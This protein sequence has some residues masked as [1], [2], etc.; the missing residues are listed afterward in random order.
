MASI[1]LTSA[2]VERLRPPKAGQSEYFDELLPSFGL[3][4]S[5]SGTQAW[6]VMTRVEGKLIRLT[7]GRH[8]GMK[9]ADARKQAQEI[10]RLAA[11]GIDPRHVEEEKRQKRQIDIDNTFGRLAEQF[12]AKHVEPNLR[13]TT[14]REYKRIL[15]GKDTARWR[16]RPVSSIKKTD[17]L[18]LMDAIDAR[19]AKTAG[20]LSLAYLRKFFNWCVD[21]DAIEISPAD[22]IKNSRKIP[23]RAR[24]LTLQELKL[25]W[26]AADAE[27]G[28]FG[29]IVKL[30]ILTGQRRNEV[31]GMRWEE[32]RDLH[33]K[34]ATWEIPEART[35]NARPHVVPLSA[36]AQAIVLRMPHVGSS[37]LLE[38]RQDA[39]IR[40]QQGQSAH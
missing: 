25:I 33:S 7:L 1:K 17:I 14:S 9:L 40:F 11:A 36:Q 34:H 12:M 6:F 32:L 3:R 39:G 29:P 16:S 20:G 37:H 27:G 26:A 31:A 18:E 35:K 30:L 21:R 15:F 22:R 19:G 24:V 13:P 8:P 4:V 10:M 28:I 5:H 38:D 23:S 2:A